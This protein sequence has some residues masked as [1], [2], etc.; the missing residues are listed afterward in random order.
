MLAVVDPDLKLLQV[1]QGLVDDAVIGHPF[2]GGLAVTAGPV[3]QLHVH[4]KVGE[5]GGV[6]PPL[7]V[8]QWV[9]SV[10]KRLRWYL[11]REPRVLSAVL[12]I[13]LSVIE[14]HFRQAS[15]ALAPHAQLGAVSFIHRF[16][17][18]LNRHVHFHCC[19]IDGVFEPAEE[20]D[21][22]GPQAVRF[23]AAAD[24]TLEAVAAIA[25]QVRIRLLRWFA[26]S[27][28]IEPDDV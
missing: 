2:D 13:F 25:E 21:D 20:A 19:V 16:G 1:L 22:A 27:G 12:H 10:P 3:G 4:P 28:L 9:L 14:T 11:E 26:L 8:R 5:E 18:S 7:P 24:L 17:A 23:R 15:A 6:F